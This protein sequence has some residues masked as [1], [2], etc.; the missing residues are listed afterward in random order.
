MS[1]D[2]EKFRPIGPYVVLPSGEK[3]T[4]FD[5]RGNQ[6]IVIQ[7]QYTKPFAFYLAK[8]PGN[9][10]IATQTVLDSR[11]MIVADA[12]SASVGDY[13]VAFRGVYGDTDDLY[14]GKIQSIATNTLTLD[15]PISH[16]F[17]IGDT[18]LFRTVDA[19]L[20]GSVTPQVL[21]LPM[22]DGSLSVDVTRI[23]FTI[24]CAT[25]PDDSKFGDLAALTNGIVLRKVSN[26]Y[27]IT[28]LCNIK[29]NGDFASL[30]YDVT[31][32]DK[33]GG[34]AYGV[35]CMLTYNAQRFFGVSIRLNGLDSLE[36]I[37][38]DDLSSLDSFHVIAE[39][40]VVE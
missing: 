4:R 14:V 3:V 19:N 16:E 27:G 40:H 23:I 31:Y 28:N 10:T 26:V 12:S 22:G 17:V 36:L 38:Q 15:T 34:G 7:D 39:G 8:N 5:I 13:A 21:D 1:I 37:I 25:E 29:T 30:S 6:Q 24:V 18:V 20:N 9:S 11:T 32:T 35:R 2:P 33:A